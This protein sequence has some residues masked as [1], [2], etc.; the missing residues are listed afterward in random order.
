VTTAGIL[1]AGIGNVFL[2]DDGFGVAVVQ[3]LAERPL[4][5]DVCLLDAGIR[6]FDL[7]LALLDTRRGAILI[8]VTRRG[9]APGQLH[10]LEPE[11]PPDG[12]ARAIEPHAL[13]PVQV[14]ALVR[15]LGQGP[16]HLYLVGCEP[17][18]LG[19]DGDIAPGL[20]APVAAAVEPAI[21]LVQALIAGI[22][23]GRPPGA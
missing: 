2:G 3:R 8:D 23:G 1:V 22:R 5:D 18:A 12:G 10:V 4:P 9:G 17:A 19:A 11:L 7:A 21:E 6:G 14:L 15:A 16:E 13:D 20:S